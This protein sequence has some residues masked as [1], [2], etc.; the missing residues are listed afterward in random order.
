MGVYYI[1]KKGKRGCECCNLIMSWKF[2]HCL[3]RATAENVMKKHAWRLLLLF[4]KVKDR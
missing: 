3:I 1:E 2:S 4:I